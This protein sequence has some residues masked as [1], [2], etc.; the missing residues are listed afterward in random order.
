MSHATLRDR[1]LAELECVRTVDCHSHTMLSREYV[2]GGPKDLFGLMSY[3]ERDFGG[4]LGRSSGEAYAGCA[5]E[6]EK[7][8][9]LKGVLDRA[10]NVSYWR[11]NLV[12]YQRLFGLQEGELTDANWAAVN[13]AIKSQTAEPGW[14]THITRE[15]AN[16]ETQMLNV[17]WFQDWEPE[18]FTA[19]LR[20]ESA[21]ELHQPQVRGAL[22]E[23]LS[24]EFGSLSQL[25]E[26]LAALV[27]EYRAR[28]SRG[29]KLAHAYAR[30]LHSEPVAASVADAIFARAL[31]GRMPSPGEVKQLQDHIIFFLAQLA[32][33]LG[34][35]FDIHTGVQANWGRIPDSDPLHLIGLLQANPKTRFS[36]YHAG[37][38]YSREIGMLA[39]HYPNV[40][41]N[42]AWMY[43]VT[44]E[45]SRQSLLEWLDLVPGERILGFG[46]DVGHPE[47]VYAHLVMARSCLADVLALK[48]ERDFLSEECAL[49]LCHKL[50]RENAL[51]LYSLEPRA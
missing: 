50:L 48:V 36:L 1:L 2:A 8:E 30:T 5:S 11:H 35:V 22:Q 3:F 43:V 4:T 7:W 37:Y 34:Q 13:E 16:L 40:W 10:R 21:L 19:I 39:K 23:R 24:R 38:P 45:G 28:G 42:M 51:R 17:P 44:M 12:M 41:L 9:V 20:M 26:G 46:S 15:V 47:M 14:Y 18:F 29:I 6:A 31:A 25:K 33:E 49:D 27:E 32:G